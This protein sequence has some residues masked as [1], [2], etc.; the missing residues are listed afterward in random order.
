MGAE[1]DDV[2]LAAHRVVRVEGGAAHARQR[3]DRQALAEGADEAGA[4]DEVAV[5]QRGRRA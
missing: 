4:L 3:L 5:A 1:D 2:P